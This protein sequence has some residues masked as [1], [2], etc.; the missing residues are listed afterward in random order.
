MA[1]LRK[2]WRDERGTETVEWAVIIG[3]IAVGAIVTAAIIGGKVTNA[4]NGLNE[5]MTGGLFD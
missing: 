4:F 3:L 5:S 1:S 2:F